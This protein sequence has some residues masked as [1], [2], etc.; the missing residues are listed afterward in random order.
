MET[1]EERRAVP[2][3]L[4]LVDA[5]LNSHSNN[6]GRMGVCRQRGL[7][8][9]PALPFFIPRGSLNEALRTNEL[10]L[11]ARVARFVQPCAYFHTDISYIPHD[12][13]HT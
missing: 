8:R 10:C 9:Y 1:R 6:K 5:V 11:Q 3:Q 12:F 4:P 7:E 13:M 2:G